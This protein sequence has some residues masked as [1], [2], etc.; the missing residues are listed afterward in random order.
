MPIYYCDE[1]Y[2]SSSVVVLKIDFN[3]GVLFM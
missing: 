2:Q 1:Y 3:H